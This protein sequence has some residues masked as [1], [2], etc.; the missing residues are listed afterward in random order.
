MIAIKPETNNYTY[1]YNT[2]MTELYL[3][4]TATAWKVLSTIEYVN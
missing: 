2:L 1:A 3:L 4:L